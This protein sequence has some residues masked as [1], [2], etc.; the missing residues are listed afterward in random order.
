MEKNEDL[1]FGIRPIIEAIKAEK[2]LEKLYIQHDLSGPLISELRKLIKEHSVVFSQVPIQKINKLTRN[3]T[4]HQGVVAKISPIKTHDIEDLVSKLIAD[5]KTPLLLL[6]DN[7]TDVRNFG[8]ICRTA[9]CAGVDAIVI[10]SRGAAPINGDALKTSAGALHRIP[11]CKV[12]NLTDAVFMLQQLD[13]QIV[14]CTEKTETTVYDANYT[15][16]T[17]IIMGSEDRGISNQLLRLC[18]HKAKIPM[19]G[20]ISSLNVSVAAG[21]ILYE[22]VKQRG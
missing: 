19:A 5:K 15:G 2:T 1:I 13:I 10:P 8:A 20:N 17:A 4:N 3:D 21:V 18:D 22:A 7:I 16:P 6:L 11:V 14:G 12:T 9:E